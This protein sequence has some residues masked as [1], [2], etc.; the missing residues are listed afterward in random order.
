LLDLNHLAPHALMFLV[1][2]ANTCKIIGIELVYNS[3]PRNDGIVSTPAQDK[4]CQP[5]LRRGFLLPSGATL[6]LSEVGEVL[7]SSVQSMP[8]C[9][10]LLIVLEVGE[11]LWGGGFEEFGGPPGAAIDL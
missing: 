3:I 6:P 4:G 5:L 11:S 8:G 1:G 7:L 2:T 9:P 10:P